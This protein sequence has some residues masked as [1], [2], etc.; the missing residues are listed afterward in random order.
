[1]EMLDLLFNPEGITV[2]VMVPNY[3]KFVQSLRHKCSHVNIINNVD[4]FF[5]NDC[6][7]MYGNPTA[8]NKL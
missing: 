8:R 3:I 2:L 6:K 1:M 4:D 5:R 7:S